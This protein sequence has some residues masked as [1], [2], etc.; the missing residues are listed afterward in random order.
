MRL[1]VVF[2]AA[3]EDRW[4]TLGRSFPTDVRPPA[5]CAVV[6]ELPEDF[7][8]A[9][10]WKQLAFPQQFEWAPAVGKLPFE[11]DFGGGEA[12]HAYWMRPLQTPRDAAGD[13]DRLAYCCIGDTQD[14][15]FQYAGPE[16][17]AAMMPTLQLDVQW[18]GTTAHDTIL[19]HS[20]TTHAGGGYVYSDAE[21][22]SPD[23]HLLAVTTL[24][25]LLK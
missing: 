21:L 4:P 17:L 18:F 10:V 22:W 11:P 5:E 24:R 19:Q 25:G 6:R 12:R 20:R 8:M 13:F 9:E 16:A 23:Q 3:G 1:H 7:P 14:S 2:G 15:Y